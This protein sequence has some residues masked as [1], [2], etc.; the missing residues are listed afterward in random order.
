MW[1]GMGVEK[2]GRLQSQ[3]GRPWRVS[4]ALLECLAFVLRA[5]G[6]HRRLLGWGMSHCVLVAPWRTNK[7]RQVVRGGGTSEEA[8][9]LVSVAET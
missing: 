1:N 5:V 9:A 2:E 8:V 3:V 4:W 6:S 7:N